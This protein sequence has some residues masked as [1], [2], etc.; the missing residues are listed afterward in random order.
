MIVYGLSDR[1]IGKPDE[2]FLSL[3][4]AQDAL[5]CSGG[6]VVM[7]EVKAEPMMIISKWRDEAME[8]YCKCGAFPERKRCDVCDQ[9]RG[10]VA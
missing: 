2:I 3:D 8:F 7:F 1:F 10:G 9:T 6:V 5:D 4:D